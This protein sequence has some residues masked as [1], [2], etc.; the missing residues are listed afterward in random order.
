M[1]GGL[2][3]AVNDLREAPPYLA[4]VVDTCKAEVLERQVTE[5]FYRFIDLNGA[6]FDLTQ[7]LS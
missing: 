1:A 2:A 5:L 4:M 6:V 7:Q 3:G